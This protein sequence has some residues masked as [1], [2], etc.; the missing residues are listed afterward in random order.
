M[1]INVL[2][3]VARL[4]QKLLKQPRPSRPDTGKNRRLVPKK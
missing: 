3:A 1:C 2:T 4:A